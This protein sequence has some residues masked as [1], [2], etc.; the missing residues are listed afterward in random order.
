MIFII[1]LKG[2]WRGRGRGGRGAAQAIGNP[3]EAG[4]DR[5]GVAN[6]VE[7]IIKS[8]GEDENHS[9]GFPYE[10]QLDIEEPADIESGEAFI[11]IIIIIIIYIFKFKKMQLIL[12]LIL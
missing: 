11:I 5:D 2:H 10:T 1:K 7:E 6:D 8:D 4:E 9:Q 3:E 12:L